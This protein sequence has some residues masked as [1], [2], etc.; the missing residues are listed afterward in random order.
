MRVIYSSSVWT[1]QINSMDVSS[2]HRWS[3]G[4]Y[5]LIF[6]YVVVIVSASG[7]SPYPDLIGFWSSQANRSILFSIVSFLIWL[8]SLYI[9]C[10]QYGGSFYIGINI[11]TEFLQIGIDSGYYYTWVLIS[12]SHC[13]GPID[14]SKPWKS[15]GFS[16][17]FLHDVI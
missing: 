1:L 2:T 15:P 11:P 4:G 13:R 10:I 3:L 14:N 17:S 9:L 5:I 8:A 16:P 7:F 6:W 12:P